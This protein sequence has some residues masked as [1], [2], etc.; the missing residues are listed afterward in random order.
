MGTDRVRRA[1]E[2][3]EG[4]LVTCT[5]NWH[6][7]C[8]INSVHWLDAEELS[9]KSVICLKIRIDQWIMFNL[10]Q[11]RKQ[12]RGN[13]TMNIAKQCLSISVLSLRMILAIFPAAPSGP[14]SLSLSRCLITSRTFFPLL[15]SFCT[16]FTTL[17]PFS[18]QTPP[19]TQVNSAYIR[20]Q[21]DSET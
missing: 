9:F 10:R 8:L 21:G 7:P 1:N 15:R 6:L 13:H 18:T 11:F 16:E 14:L 3:G 19:P 12:K 2:R 20:V 4:S 5:L 17:F